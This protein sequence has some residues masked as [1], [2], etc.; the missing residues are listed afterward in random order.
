VR[1]VDTNSAHFSLQVFCVHSAYMRA[2]GSAFARKPTRWGGVGSFWRPPLTSRRRF[3]AILFARITL[4]DAGASEVEAMIVW[5]G[6][7]CRVVSTGMQS[8]ISLSIRAPEMGRLS[9]C[10]TRSPAFFN[11]KL[12]IIQCQKYNVYLHWYVSDTPS[13]TFKVLYVE[14]RRLPSAVLGRQIP[15]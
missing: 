14:Q 11:T 10:F 5:G 8:R 15:Q 6:L 7:V 4:Q 1:N 12:M 3:L 9:C 2:A 13:R